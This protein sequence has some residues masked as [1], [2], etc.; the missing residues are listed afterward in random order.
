MSRPLKH[1]PEISPR[2]SKELRIDHKPI[3]IKQ[4]S[5]KY[6]S[7]IEHHAN[8][9]SEFSFISHVES[10]PTRYLNLVGF[11]LTTRVNPL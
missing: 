5:H 3:I 7:C 11:T 9:C 10:I 4:P 2:D 6:I 8:I 1:D